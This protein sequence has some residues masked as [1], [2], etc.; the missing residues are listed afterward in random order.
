MVR[1]VISYIDLSDGGVE[2]CSCSKDN[3]IRVY[4]NTNKIVVQGEIHFDGVI[5]LLSQEGKG[6]LPVGGYLFP[7]R[8][9]IVIVIIIPYF[10]C[11]GRGTG[12]AT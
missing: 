11:T 8:V 2:G 7:V 4:G 12:R 3:S 10:I 1:P 5:C 9:I 6:L